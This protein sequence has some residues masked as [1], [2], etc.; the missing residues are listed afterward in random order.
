[1]GNE[2][3]FFLDMD[4]VIVGFLEGCA[5]LFNSPL[6]IHKDWPK[7]CWGDDKIMEK[8]FG[9]SGNEFWN[10]L[11]T[12]Y[13]W[14]NLPWSFD[15]LEIISILYQHKPIILTSPING[16]ADGK[17]SWIK[18]QLPDYHKDGRYMIGSGKHYIAT[19]NYVLIDDHDDNIQAWEKAG[20]VGILYPRP[21]NSL[22]WVL[23][24]DSAI[25]YFKRDVDRAVRFSKF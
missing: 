25:N 12:D 15:G 13:F 20:G 2:L 10:Q 3:K 5:E 14:A 7:G 24:F 21:W 6:D 9:C 1:M 11:R 17:I 19:N 4:G 22:H 18:N 8:F 23:D 16:G